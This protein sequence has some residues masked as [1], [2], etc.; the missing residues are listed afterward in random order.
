MF[1]GWQR[2]PGIVC[3]SRWIYDRQRRLFR[4]ALEETAPTR[5]FCGCRIWAVP[6]LMGGSVGGSLHQ[7]HRSG[8]RRRIRHHRPGIIHGAM[9]VDSELRSIFLARLN[10]SLAGFEGRVGG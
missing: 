8:S 9:D 10:Q 2:N 6:L 1:A 5:A 7:N 4:G 3:L